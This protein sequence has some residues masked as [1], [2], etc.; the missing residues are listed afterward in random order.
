MKRYGYIYSKIHSMDNL[1]LA[2]KMAREDKSFY[3]EVRMV[4]NNEDYYL[5]QIQDMLINKTYSITSEDY[6][7][8]EKNDKGKIRKIYKTN[9]FPH[10]IIQWALML[11]IQDILLKSFIDNTFASIPERGIHK[12]LIKMDYD[13]RNDV[14]NTQYALQ[15]DVRK[16]YPSINH[17]INKKQYRR[18]FKDDDLLWLIDMLIDSLCLDDEGNILVDDDIPDDEKKGI[19]IGSLFSQWDG[20]YFVSPLDHWLKEN[21]NI[22]YL[23]RYCDDIVILAKTK[24]ELH[25]IRK[26]IEKYLQE[27]LKLDLKN[28]Y[29]IFPVDK[30]GIDFVGYRHF[31]TYILLRKTTSQKL[32]RTMRD[33]NKKI[34]N[35]EEFTYTDYCSINSYKGWLEWANCYNL[36]EKWIVPL[37]PYCQQ[38]Y[39]ENINSTKPF[40]MEFNNKITTNYKG[41]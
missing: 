17:E 37:I 33:I 9:Y 14:E 25:S 11:Q 20:N 41:W 39:K 40:S 29:K 6:T 1:K 19:A 22:K 21:K 15:I 30:Q 2:H 23:Y 36:Y 24:E 38:Y 4:D 31:R 35:G 27:N 3:D 12:A 7:M 26:D 18:K 13:L 34:E 10:R 8:I 16:F 5:K 28:N 32:I